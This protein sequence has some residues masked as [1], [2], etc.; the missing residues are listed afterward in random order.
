M[1]DLIG[2]F[3]ELDGGEKVKAETPNFTYVFGKDSS[4]LGSDMVAKVFLTDK[5]LLFLTFTEFSDGVPLNDW[6]KY[7]L[8]FKEESKAGN[9]FTKLMENFSNSVGNAQKSFV[10]L[11][12]S[13]KVTKH[14][15]MVWFELPLDGMERIY[16]SAKK[17]TIVYE[18]HKKSW[19]DI[20]RGKPEVSF[21]VETPDIWRIH[22]EA[23]VKGNQQKE[24]GKN[25]KKNSICPRCG[26][27]Y[28]EVTVKFVECP[29]CSEFVCREK[30]LGFIKK[31]W[32][33]T[34]CFDDE[35]YLCIKCIKR[36]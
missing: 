30:K 27:K 19:I 28:E 18:K 16:A 12:T 34:G 26:T 25:T 32:E 36:K 4:L 35:K 17:L 6:Q 11:M 20:F 23:F 22:L 10:E 21:L 29:E 3:K 9:K 2:F 8:S 33:S 13:G 14:I 15:S 31:S 1:T 5:R 24:N 7:A